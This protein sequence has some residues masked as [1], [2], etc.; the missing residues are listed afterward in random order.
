METLK[1]T[2]KIA[3]ECLLVVISF[4]SAIALVFGWT[5]ATL[6]QEVT[7]SVVKISAMDLLDE[8]E[9]D[10]AWEVRE[11]YKEKV[12]VV[13]GRVASIDNGGRRMFLGSHSEFRIVFA[14]LTRPDPSFPPGESHIF[15]GDSQWP[16]KV[17]TVT[18]VCKSG[19]YASTFPLLNDCVEVCP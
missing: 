8:Y 14:R 15:P 13:T 7:P 5:P 4:L 1:K 6:G 18:L 12:M 11:K 10:G 3:A 16:R 2:L 19:G 9:T 17:R